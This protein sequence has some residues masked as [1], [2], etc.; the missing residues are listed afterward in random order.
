MI[1]MDDVYGGTNRY[2]RKIATKMGIEVSFVDATIPSNVEK[3]LKPNTKMVR[4]QI[5]F[6]RVQCN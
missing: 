4:A 3:A 1:S 5:I 6:R 2:F